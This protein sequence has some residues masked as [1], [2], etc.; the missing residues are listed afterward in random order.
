MAEDII[1]PGIKI[2]V[3]YTCKPATQICD[4]IALN[5]INDVARSK[6]N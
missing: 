6:D 3:Y 4:L 2:L 1:F 5:L